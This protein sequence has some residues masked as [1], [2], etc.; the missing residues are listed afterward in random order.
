MT[1]PTP[2]TAFVIEES[3]AVHR[4]WSSRYV[5][6]RKLYPVNPYEVGVPSLGLLIVIG[7]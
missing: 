2:L 7:L 4:A 6:S 1:V 3:R 5:L